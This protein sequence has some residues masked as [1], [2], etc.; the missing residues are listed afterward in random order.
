[1]TSGDSTGFC[2]ARALPEHLDSIKS[3]ADGHKPELG[4]VRRPT[5][6]KAITDGEVLIAELSGALAGFAHYHHR[7]D[8]QTTLYNIV[9]AERFRHRGIGAALM[10]EVH[11]EARAL[12]KEY[13]LLKCPAELDANGFYCRLGFSLAYMEKGKHRPLNVWTLST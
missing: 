1:M 10:A 6:A 4:F 11:S 13:V 3:I 7:R 2:T 9:V 8:A 5:L 12:G